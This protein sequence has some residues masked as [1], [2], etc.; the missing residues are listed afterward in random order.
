M[1]ARKWGTRAASRAVGCGKDSGHGSG[2]AFCLQLVPAGGLPEAQR[3]E[4]WSGDLETWRWKWD[5]GVW[6]REVVRR[7]WPQGSG[8]FHL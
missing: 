1:K 2:I 7:E 4:H 3:A 8:T 6:G 5:K